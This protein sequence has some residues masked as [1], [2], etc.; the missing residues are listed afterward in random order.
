MVSLSSQITSCSCQEV[1][2]IEKDSTNYYH[3]TKVKLAMVAAFDEGTGV[4]DISI[5][6][7]S[8]EGL[9]NLRGIYGYQMILAYRSEDF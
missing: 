5:D 8:G 6:G 1:Q 9:H 3:K 2:A 4:N 7:S